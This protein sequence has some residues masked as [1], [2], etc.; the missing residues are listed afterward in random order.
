MIKQE[1]LEQALKFLSETDEQHAKLV[2][3]VDL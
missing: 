3:G 2:S 1:R